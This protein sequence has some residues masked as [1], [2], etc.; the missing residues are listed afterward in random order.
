MYVKRKVI[1]KTIKGLD[2]LFNIF[3]ND[4][5]NIELGTVMITSSIAPE[6]EK[7]LYDK[8][9]KV[10]TMFNVADAL[11]GTKNCNGVPMKNEFWR[12]QLTDSDKQLVYDLAHRLNSGE[13]NADKSIPMNTERVTSSPLKISAFEKE[14]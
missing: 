8:M 4:L 6:S 5:P 10:L 13:Y 2:T 12:V 1:G 9:S 11:F 14:F 7:Y 3:M